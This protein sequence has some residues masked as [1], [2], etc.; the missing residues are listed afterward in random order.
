M[1][2]FNRRQ[3]A[4]RVQQRFRQ[5]AEAWPDFQY[6]LPRLHLGILEQG[7]EHIRVQEEILPQ[8]P[9]GMQVQFLQ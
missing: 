1:V 2:Q 4:S 8:F 6:A 3:V 9:A 5:H 7:M